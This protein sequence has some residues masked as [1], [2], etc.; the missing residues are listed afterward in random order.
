MNAAIRRRTFMLGTA[1]AVGSWTPSARASGP[2]PFV[3][4]MHSHYALVGTT[5][6]VP[7]E[8][9][10]HLEENGATL[11]A[12][13]LVDD[14]PWIRATP[15]GIVQV[16]QPAPGEI[17]AWF[18]RGMQRVEAVRK[19]N[20]LPQALTP[21]DVDAAAAGQPHA[22]MACESANFLEGDVGRL[23]QAYA[24]GL[25][26]LQV[27][28][29]IQTPLGDLQTTAPTHHGMPKLARELFAECKRLGILVDMA[30]S[31]P[32]FVEQALDAS[33]AAF[34]WS[35]GWVRQ[36]GNPQWNDSGYLARSLSPELAKQ[37]AAR[38]GVLGLWSVRA[39][40]DSSYP[41]YS[42]GSYADEI[43]RMADLLGPKAV[44]FG[45]DLS[46]AGPDPV[47]ASYADVREVVNQLVRRGM[48]EA[49]LQD[50]CMGNY[51]RV[52]KAA[53][54]QRA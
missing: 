38:G 41:L 15:R 14:L 28:H 3:A 19:A 31:T 50:I 37:M 26:H 25:R 22:V 53:M 16:S 29:Y 32:A 45:T 13:K 43:A 39:R 6:P 30:H 21:A 33:D 23:A 5:P 9:R 4:D 11:V 12:M 52:L 49:V 27:V 47:L 34:V 8:L 35:H 24:M 51:A 54:A 48:P 18:Q 1:A 2:K 44:A 10:R 42:I 36:R 40:R 17:W 20:G 46:G 7:G